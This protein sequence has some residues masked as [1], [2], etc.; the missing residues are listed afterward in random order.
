MRRRLHIGQVAASAGV[1]VQ[2]VRYY[3]RLGLLPVPPRA[4][5]GYRVYSSEIVKRLQ[6]IRRALGLGFR[7]EEI[8]EIVRTRFVGQ[9][10]CECVQRMLQRKLGEVEEQILNPARFRRQVRGLLAQAHTLPRRSHQAT[11]ICPLIE[12]IPK[13]KEKRRQSSGV[14]MSACF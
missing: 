4:P 10:P 5:S 2:A 9:S 1:S 6:F 11:A 8:R 7:L 13:Q 12:S 3:E 14:G